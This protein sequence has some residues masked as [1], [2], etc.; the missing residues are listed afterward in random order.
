MTHAERLA[1]AGPGVSAQ[2][3]TLRLQDMD[4][5]AHNDASH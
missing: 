2:K 3:R 4:A 5:V 1:A